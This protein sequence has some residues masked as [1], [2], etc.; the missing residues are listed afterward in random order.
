MA[1]DKIGVWDPE[2]AAIN[3]KILIVAVSITSR[4]KR[5][6]INDLEFN[7]PKQ[8]IIK[9]IIAGKSI[10]VSNVIDFIN[11]CI[12]LILALSIAA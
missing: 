12:F 5:E 7:I 8:P 3:T 2:V 9:R 1:A 4:E 6:L 10:M 11:A